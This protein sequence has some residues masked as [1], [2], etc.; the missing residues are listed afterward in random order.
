M[1]DATSGSA[2][3]V[4]KLLYSFFFVVTWNN[5]R[6]C[7]VIGGSGVCGQAHSSANDVWSGRQTRWVPSNH[8]RQ[9]MT[10][11][12]NKT[13]SSPSRRPLVAAVWI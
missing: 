13:P 6:E 4:K 9:I 10:V 11:R 1:I 5:S 2:Q 3:L 8:G 7:L 12:R